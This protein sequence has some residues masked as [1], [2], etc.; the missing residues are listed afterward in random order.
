V[1]TMLIGSDTLHKVSK[2]ILEIL[3]NYYK[4]A[5]E[6]CINDKEWWNSYTEPDKMLSSLKTCQQTLQKYIDLCN[7]SDKKHLS[8]SDVPEQSDSTGLIQTIYDHLKIEES[9]NNEQKIEKIPL[10]YYDTFGYYYVDENVIGF[11]CKDNDFPTMEM[12]N[13]S[14]KAINQKYGINIDKSDLKLINSSD[15]DNFT[16]VIDYT[17]LIKIYSENYYNSDSF[18]SQQALHNAD[19][20]TKRND[21]NMKAYLNDR[22]QNIGRKLSMQNGK[23]MP[24][25]QWKA[26]HSTSE[27]IKH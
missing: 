27:N 20:E 6:I 13:K 8:P 5:L 24:L 2:D 15:I 16:D 9:V 26:L 23:E 17:D 14:I 4:K 11:N 21:I 22:N 18:K 12:I 25:S 19:Y 1:M 7:N 10:K 3:E